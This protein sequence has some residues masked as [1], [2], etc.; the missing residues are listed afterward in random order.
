MAALEKDNGRRR[1]L[2]SRCDSEW[3]F[4][5]LGCP[6]CPNEDPAQ[7]GYYPG[8]DNI[9]RLNVCERCRR[10]LKTIDLREAAGER[11]LPAERI[12]T[13]GMDLAAKEAGYR[14]GLR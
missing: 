10:Y 4:R 2:C 14:A 3:T 13:V 7:L 1:L 11:C 12:L 6:F 8:D 9:Y 5:R